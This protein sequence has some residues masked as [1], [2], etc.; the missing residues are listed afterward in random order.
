M[1]ENTAS[2]SDAI[3]AIAAG[4]IVLVVDD[5]D[6]E[7]EGDLIMAA[8]AATREKVAFFLR[9]TSGVVCVSLAGRRCDALQLPLMVTDNTEAQGTAFT[10]SVDLVE[11][12]TTGISAADRAATIRG[13]ADHSLGPRDF[14]RPGHIFP[15]RSRDGGVLRRAGH[16]EAA[17]D[18]A[19]MAG[20]G[21]AGVLCEVVSADKG[22]MARGPE[23]RRLAARYRLPM[24]SIA[25]LMAHRLRRERLV[26]QIAEAQL[27]TR[28]GVFACQAWRSKLDGIE[29]LTMTL[30]DVDAGAPVLVRVHSECL[31]GD[32]LGSR[33]CDCG[34]QLDDSLAAISAEGRGV[35]VYLRGHEGRGI[36]LAHKLAAY[37]LQE[38]GHDTVDAN[39]LLGLPVDNREYA[40]GA[41]ILRELG[42]R[43]LRLMTNNPAKCEGLKRLGLEI[44]ERVP[45]APRTTSE[46]VAYLEAKRQR[47]GH[48]L[49]ELQLTG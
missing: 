42:V 37:R 48:L 31:T 39:L 4:E 21:A 1:S 10:V 12:T 44:V 38:Q 22:T 7:N 28:H 27:P 9:H 3:R 35:L 13:L 14:A 19:E 40:I 17:A 32:V 45:L 43:S 5:E 24:I 18:L 49:T 16:T 2:V 6:R 23:L 46:N 47:M 36:G 20:R 30:G 25:E 15:L 26:E 29:H 8:E 34:A 41:Q 11:G 33:R